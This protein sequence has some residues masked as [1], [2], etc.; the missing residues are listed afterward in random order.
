MSNANQPY[1]ICCFFSLATK[2]SA[3]RS[4]ALHLLDIRRMCLWIYVRV[5]SY[6]HICQSEMW[7]IFFGHRETEWLLFRAIA[8]RRWN[9]YICISSATVALFGFGVAVFCLWFHVLVIILPFHSIRSFV[10]SLVSTTS[11]CS[12]V[13]ACVL[14][15]FFFGGIHICFACW[16]ILGSHRHDTSHRQR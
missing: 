2:C 4:F 7:S 9:S 12:C 16:C 3:K 8:R 1:F 10:H 15:R 11:W 14:F 5:H 6:R 13:C